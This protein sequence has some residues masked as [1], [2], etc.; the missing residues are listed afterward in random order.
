MLSAR[1]DDWTSAGLVLMP[2]HGELAGEQKR[3]ADSLP[4]TPSLNSRELWEGALARRAV[5]S[6]PKENPA[7]NLDGST[8]QYRKRILSVHTYVLRPSAEGHASLDGAR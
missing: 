6:S 2:R 3:R 7:Q 1:A 8:A 5:S 4:L